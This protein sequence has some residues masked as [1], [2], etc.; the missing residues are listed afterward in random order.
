M[1]PIDGPLPA[2][3]GS[4]V[5][6]VTAA[7]E[8][9]WS[10]TVEGAWLSLKA[11]SSGQGDGTVELAAAPNPDPAMRRGAVVA[12]GQ[13][14]EISQAAGECE[15]SLAESSASFTQ[16]GGNGQVQVRA[17][18]AQCAWSASSDED[19]LRLRTTSGQ[20]NGTVAFEV[21]ASTAPPRSGTITISGQKFSVTQ[22]EGC[23][24]AITPAS[25]S[26]SPAGAN[27]AVTIATSPACPWTAAS[28]VPWIQVSPASGMGPAPVAVTV[29]ATAGKSRAGTAVIAGQPFTVTQAQGCS[30]AVQPSTATIG[31]SGGTVTVA[32]T[33]N[34]ECDWTATSN[35]SWITIQGRASGSGDATVTLNVAATIGPSRSGSV[36]VGGQR[37]TVSQTQGCS[38]S[39]SPENASAPSGAST[40]KVSVTTAAGCNWT[41]SSSASWLTISS[42]ASG[43]GNGDVNYAVAATSGPG[44]SATLTVAGK[45]FTLNQGEGCTFTLSSSSGNV[46]DSGGTGSFNVQTASGCDWTAS[47]S[48]GWLTITGGSSGTGN[49]TVRYSAAA[50][51]GPPRNGTIVAGGK[52]F[53]V[54][55]GDGCSYGLSATTHSAAAAGGPGSVNVTAG[56]GCGWT[57]TSDA[58]W[59]TVTS[60]ASGTSNG[61]V[62]FAVAANSGPARS[63]KLTIGGQQLTVNQAEA[64]TFSIT[65]E[66][67][68]L[69]AGAG[70]TS[71]A[72]TAT[73]GC[74]WSATA[75]APWITVASGAS[76]NGNG[77]VQLNV[78]AN[79]GGNR[80]AT[81][82]I[83]GRTFSIDQ[84]SGCTFVVAPET[85]PAAAAGG[86]AHVDITAAASCGWTAASAAGWITITSPASGTGNGA[87]DMTI[88]AN[89]GPA[90]SGTLQIAGRTVTV[91][92][93]SG[94]TVTLGSPS[95]TIAAG[96]GGGT[97]A[98][99]TTAAC[100]WTA[101]SNAPWI[102][103]TSGSP[104]AGPGSVQYS[105]AANA[106]G[107][108]RSG[109]IAIGNAVFTVNQQ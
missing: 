95:E 26:A 19:W 62:N 44:R 5:I 4:A 15:L 29:A 34:R 64:C 33:A 88:A 43:S 69:G 50:N 39:I 3:G 40:G 22:S 54:Q 89:D 32:L 45:T 75:N 9:A 67:A 102:T 80:S 8:C 72:V 77:T 14:T 70:S 60:G 38:F 65:P 57:A 27:G 87:V 81:A 41:A 11:G 36:M 13:R 56:S 6:N 7:R 63:G 18:S 61:T 100:P 16:A 58:P 35:D 2:A 48:A 42:G 73:N 25:M 20:G 23:T 78:E 104:G 106:T 47:S 1:Q 66:N 24:F 17:S 107:A 30:Y 21:P 94:C 28:N 68:T 71:V 99:A 92:Q 31:A 10:A 12:N 37:V 109:T 91:N 51:S 55:Q 101:T 59:L 74:A 90:R 79:T 83:A 82:T 53:T 85:L 97:I 76:G 98:V 84:S 52:T 96:G 93:D 86:S 103:I 108:P 49:G 46:D 105:V